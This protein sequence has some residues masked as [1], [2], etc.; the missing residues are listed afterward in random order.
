MPNTPRLTCCCH[1]T[2]PDSLDVVILVRKLLVVEAELIHEVGC[3][4]L[5]LVLGEGL[6]RDPN[7][8]ITE[9]SRD[10]P[11]TVSG[12]AWKQ[13]LQEGIKIAGSVGSRVTQSSGI[14]APRWIPA[15]GTA[16]GKPRGAEHAGWEQSSGSCS[17]PGW[18]KGS[19]SSEFPGNS[20]DVPNSPVAE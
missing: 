19:R 1:Q 20:E 9:V 7:K 16:L 3:H 17:T 2:P 15:Q 12:A 5:D 6:G 18:T 8:S 11:E 13:L 4:L 14:P 10:I